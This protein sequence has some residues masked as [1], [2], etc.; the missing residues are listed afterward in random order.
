MIQ[1]NLPPELEKLRR[2]IEGYAKG[3]GLDCFDTIFE[4]LD[5]DELNA[6][7]AGGGFP[8]RYPHWRIGMTYDQLEKG[9]SWGVQKIYELV[10]NTDPCYAYLMNAN[11]YT[12]Q[13]LV[14]AHVYGHCDF[15]K[16]NIWF[17]KTNRKML[18]QM[19]NHSV[20][21]RR[22]IDRL[23]EDVVEA[24]IDRCLSIEELIDAYAPFVPVKTKGD[25]SEFSASNPPKIKAPR[26]YL[27][28]FMN[29]K[30]YL[31]TQ[32]QKVEEQ[33]QQT[34]NFPAEPERD[35]MKFLLDYGRLD[36]W[37]ADILAMIREE[38]YYFAPQRVTK[39]MN[40]GWASY[41]HSKILTEKALDGC[42]FVDF[43]DRHAGVM[44]TGQGQLNPYKL[45]IELFRH[46]E[47]RWNKGKFGKD[48]ENCDDLRLKKAWD[49]KLG[50]GKEK[51]FEVRRHSNDITF[52]DEY[53]TEE[54]CE[55]QRYYTYALN[56]RTNKYEIK[57]R[58]WKEVKEEIL[59][60]IT[61]AGNPMIHVKD[62]NFRNRGE[63]LLE[64]RHLG[65]DLDVRYVKA[66]LE[67]VSVLWGRPAHLETLSDNA[68][69][70]YTWENGEFR[71]EKEQPKSS[72]GDKGGDRSQR[73]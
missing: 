8:K 37:Q 41:W 58:D 47:E 29:P 48:Y 46:I 42:E 69:K 6:I 3:Y 38:S 56:P 23:G 18:D 65:R 22:Y 36:A 57:T 1:S 21:V 49:K 35:V 17:S 71:E 68:K 53:F 59:A 63:L 11:S 52:I 25:E 54:F 33:I 70:I 4:M 32:R 20:R 44:A 55:D 5:Y 64:H 60:A 45:G 2:E 62:G 15:F 7:A 27:D 39:I 30:E 51:I 61:N 10:I 12:D 19:A 67:N 28:S 66:T 43:A 72:K 26:S 40:E 24:F 31:D 14:M 13:K 50:L 9:Y 73:R 34:K 16:N